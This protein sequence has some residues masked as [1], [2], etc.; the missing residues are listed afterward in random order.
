MRPPS[1]DPCI[2]VPVE[3]PEGGGAGGVSGT[4]ERTQSSV[5]VP[6]DVWNGHFCARP[7]DNLWALEMG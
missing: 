7:T 2:C 5:T 4:L 6:D 3:G 1:F